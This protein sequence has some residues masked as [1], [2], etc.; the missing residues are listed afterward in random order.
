MSHGGVCAIVYGA[1]EDPVAREVVAAVEQ[2]SCPPGTVTTDPVGLR[3]AVAAAQSVDAEWVWLLDG[4]AVPAPE[5]LEALLIETAGSPARAL[6]SS[7]VLGPGGGLDPGSLPRHVIYATHLS[8]A[9]AEHHLIQLR[10]AGSGSVLIRRRDI[11]RV[12]PVR[13]DPGWEMIELSARILRDP[14]ELGYL[15]PESVVT[16]RRP[17]E[18]ADLVSRVRSLG[19][20]AWTPREKLREGFLLTR[21]LGESATS[22]RRA[23]RGR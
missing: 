18:Q 8:V 11:P 5:A 3:P 4:G 1:P 21:R 7:K 12:G 9:A 6:L 2:Q 15:V 23:G 14:S 10:A 16:R 20:R 17:L 13:S 22:T 19:G